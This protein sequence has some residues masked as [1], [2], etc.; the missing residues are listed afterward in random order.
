MT[1]VDIWQQ[2][3]IKVS[4][5][6]LLKREFW[7]NFIFLAPCCFSA[8]DECM[9]AV[10]VALKKEKTNKRR[11]KAKIMDVASCGLKPSSYSD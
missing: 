3:A 9:L 2:A 10:R 11:A 5:R 4:K 1:G 7:W 6:V 8:G